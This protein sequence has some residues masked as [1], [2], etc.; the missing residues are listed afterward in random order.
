ME[1]A[2]KKIARRREPV[3]EGGCRPLSG[4]DQNRGRRVNGAEPFPADF[5]WGVATVAFQ[6]EAAINADGLGESIWDRFSH[7]PGNIR[8]GDTADVARDHYHGGWKT[9]GSWQK[10]V[11]LA[12]GSRSPGP[13]S[14]PAE[15]AK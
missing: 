10:S 13:G 14:S 12:V 6:I 15:L 5:V 1:C 11:S 9:S 2:R 4:A 3:A 8:N 7:T